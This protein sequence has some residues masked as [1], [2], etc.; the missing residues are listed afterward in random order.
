[1]LLTIKNFRFQENLKKH[2]NKGKTKYYEAKLSQQ[3]SRESFSIFRMRGTDNRLLVEFI[4]Y[5]YFILFL[6]VASIYCID[7]YEF[8]LLS[9]Y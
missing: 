9:L 2:K 5:Y 4:F 6:G 7:F 1:M 3:K 8:Y